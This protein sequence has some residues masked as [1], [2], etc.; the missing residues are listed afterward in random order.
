V[1]IEVRGGGGSGC[2]GG[3]GGGGG[4]RDALAVSSSAIFIVGWAVAA[5]AIYLGK[6][7]IFKKYFF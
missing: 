6:K 3:G 2:A 7:N 4:V 1:C 5:V